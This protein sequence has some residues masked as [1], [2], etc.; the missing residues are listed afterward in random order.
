[1]WGPNLTG[2]CMTDAG[3]IHTPF[4]D[5]N[6]FRWT[7]STWLAHQHLRR[8]DYS[9]SS[10][11]TLSFIPVTRLLAHGNQGRGPWPPQHESL[12]RGAVQYGT[13]IY[14]DK[15]PELV[16]CYQKSRIVFW[17]YA[18]ERAI[19]S[20]HFR[21]TTTTSNPVFQMRKCRRDGLWRFAS[22][23]CAFMYG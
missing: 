20:S 19:V 7:V 11:A 6:S 9:K 18:G 15:Q 5:Q 8:W 13:P 21:S 4:I 23:N 12:S 22:Q 1:M 2:L 14:K 16:L 17:H 3:I 10:L